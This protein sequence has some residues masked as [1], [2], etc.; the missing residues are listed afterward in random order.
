MRALTPQNLTEK[1]KK[2][3]KGQSIVRKNLYPLHLLREDAEK[4]YFKD[5]KLVFKV[6]YTVNHYKQNL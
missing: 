2:Q 5:V 4:L 1:K 3:Q 6:F